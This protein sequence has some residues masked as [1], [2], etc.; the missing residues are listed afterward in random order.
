[1]EFAVGLVHV[2]VQRSI[3]AADTIIESALTNKEVEK[4]HTHAGSL[5]QQ[6]Q[7]SAHVKQVEKF[8]YLPAESRF[9]GIINDCFST[10]S[11]FDTGQSA[12]N[13]CGFVC[14]LSIIHA[15]ARIVDWV[16]GFFLEV[17]FM[18]KVARV[19]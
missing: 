18:K 17:K 10:S 8:L 7:R 13:T 2:H 15:A 12:K 11:L 6:Q 19:A 1:M 3:R 14:K 9:H 16:S 4:K 5:C